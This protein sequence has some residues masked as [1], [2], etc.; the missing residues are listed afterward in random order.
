MPFKSLLEDKNLDLLRRGFEYDLANNLSR[1]SG[2]SVIS[3]ESSH[4]V[5]SYTDSETISRLEADYLINGIFRPLSNRVKFSVQ[6]TRVKDARI[7]FSHDY[8]ESRETMMD[9]QEEIIQQIVNILQQQIDFDLLSFSYKK[10]KVQLAAYENYLLGMEALKKGDAEYDLQARNYFERALSIEPKY[11]RAYTGISLSYFN[12]WSCRLWE[13]WDVA[14]NGAQEY[15][16]KALELD[17]QDHIALAV[18]GRTVL[19]SE[20]YAKAEHYLRKSLLINPNDANN[21]IQVA[22]SMIFLGLNREAADLYQRAIKLNPFH[23]DI[24]F[25]YGANIYFELGDFKKCIE[26][27]EK[28]NHMQLWVD[29]PVYMAA[30]CFHLGD[31]A[32]MEREWKRYLS[33]YSAS[34]AGTSRADEKQALEW[35]ISVN[36]Y[37]GHTFLRP[38]R[39]SIKKRLGAGWTVESASIASDPQKEEAHSARFWKKGDY[40]EVYYMGIAAPVKDS[41]GMGDISRLLQQ[42]GNAV[43]CSELIGAVLSREKGIELMD[44][45]AK[46]N[47]LKRIRELQGE[48]ADAETRGDFRALENLHKEYD[49][50]IAHISGSFGLGKKVRLSNTS[51]DKARAAVTLRIKSTIKKIHNSHPQLARHFELSIKTGTFCSYRPEMRVNWDLGENVTGI[52]DRELTM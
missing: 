12:E 13:R 33:Q 48:L 29:F 43:H 30:A 27:G 42:P 31:T 46:N 44:R 47:Y 11:A 7:I 52:E 39:E 28:V 22:Y 38:F 40:W 32:N 35:Q 2:L 9:A 16:L 8:V 10:D 18:A 24:Y 1:F 19:F 49:T 5:R 26:L 34:I 23:G 25:A 3:P 17:E 14:R 4:R 50:L 37:K 41:K 21:L 51:I 6:F 20:E 36:P 15:A 45:H